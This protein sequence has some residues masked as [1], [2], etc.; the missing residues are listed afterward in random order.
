MK[1]KAE[2]DDIDDLLNYI[3][4]FVNDFDD[5][6]TSSTQDEDSTSLGITSVSELDQDKIELN[7]PMDPVFISSECGWEQKFLD[8]FKEVIRGHLS[9]MPVI[10]FSG[11]PLEVEK[12][13]Q[14]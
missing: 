2:V 3:S 4:N 8:T 5:I 13:G 6:G 10:L 14:H 1:R 11:S 7:G 9:L 12:A